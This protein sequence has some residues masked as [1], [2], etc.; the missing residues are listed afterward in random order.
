MS[1][2]GVGWDG[3]NHRRRT[4]SEPPL[5]PTMVVQMKMRLFFSAYSGESSVSAAA[6]SSPHSSATCV[7]VGVGG[8]GMSGRCQCGR[9][10]AL[11]LTLCRQAIDK[12]E[13]LK[14]DLRKGKDGQRQNTLTSRDPHQTAQRTAHSPV[15]RPGSPPRQPT[16]HSP[17]STAHTAHTHR[18]VGRLD[19]DVV[20][21][22]SAASS[23]Y[24]RRGREARPGR[25]SVGEN[26][27]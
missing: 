19:E 14:N 11:L 10:D 1:K 6:A 24:T 3:V 27:L 22:P 25:E 13:L 20:R 9:Q 17:L 23:C 8:G 26:R 16:P 5:T 7:S 4:S 18:A 12:R 2:K 21:A 15:P